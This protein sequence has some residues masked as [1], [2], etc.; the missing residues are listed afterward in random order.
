M[1]MLQLTRCSL[2][3]SFWPQNRLLK[4]NTH[5]RSPDLAPSDFLLFLKIK[6]S[7][8]G[9]KFQEIED[10]QKKITTALEAIPQQEFQKRFQ[11]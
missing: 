8:K 7:L 6:S 1:T 9:R 10:I 5:P 2:P 11:Q 4:W 3:S